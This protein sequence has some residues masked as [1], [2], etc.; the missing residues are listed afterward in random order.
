MPST[1]ESASPDV[2]AFVLQ[3][4]GSL[5]ASQV[6]AL[7]AL[8]RAGITPD[9]VVGSSAG[10]LNG[11]AFAA[12]PSIEGID[13]LEALW[14]NIKRRHV[15]PISLRTLVMAVVGRGEAAVSSAG[16]G[17]LLRFGVGVGRLEDVVV[18]VHVVATDFETGAAVVLSRG[19]AVSALLASAAFPGLYPPVRVGEHRLIDGGVSADTPVLQAEALGATKIYVLPAAVTKQTGRQA[20]AVLFA[21]YQAVGHILDERERR[22]VAAVRGSVVRLPAADTPVGSLIDF[23]DTRRLIQA[24]Y[25]LTQDWLA[26][27]PA[28]MA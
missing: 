22:D 27:Q 3:G 11:V 5:C 21:A 19:N 25:S 26:R 7:R 6:G 4:G 12:D 17:K 9:L 24:G 20:H 14:L 1:A 15:A 16:L 23:S 18:P 13:R 2:V 28:V 10:A 8:T